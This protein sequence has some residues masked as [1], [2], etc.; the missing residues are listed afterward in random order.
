MATDNVQVSSYAVSLDGQQVEV[1]SG[2]TN[3]FTVTTKDGSTLLLGVV[4]QD[5]AGNQSTPI[6]L[7]FTAPDVSPP[8]WTEPFVTW[9]GTEDSITL[10]WGTA[11][12]NQGVVVYHIFRDNELIATS[13]SPTAT[14]EDLPESSTWAFRIEAG[15]AAGNWSTDG[16]ATA[17][18]TKAVYDPGFRRLSKE[19]YARTVAALMPP[20]WAYCPPDNLSP[21]MGYC[22]TLG[23]KPIGIKSRLPNTAF[24]APSLKIIPMTSP[25]M[26]ITSYAEVTG[27]STIGYMTS[28][29]P[30]GSLAL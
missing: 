5:A 10:S 4:A 22:K 28:T 9:T 20:F 17:A 1:V 11:T 2:Q 30:P 12:D 18:T 13:T 29:H 21:Q 14:I 15:D 24:G 7:T 25:F 26:P 6:Q 3:T 27:G 19:Q 16:P 8:T 23:P